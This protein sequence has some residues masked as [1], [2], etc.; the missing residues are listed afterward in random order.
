M[1]MWCMCAPLFQRSYTAA[2][3]LV[4]LYFAISWLF[5][6]VDNTLAYMLPCA[7]R[8][9]EMRPGEP[10]RKLSGK[11][12]S[13]RDNIGGASQD[14]VR[15]CLLVCGCVIHCPVDSVLLLKEE[16]YTRV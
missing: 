10:M 9:D 16:N 1:Q 13:F 5:A 6:L 3:V 4:L 2:V 11:K 15:V 14:K 12:R 8:F 7:I